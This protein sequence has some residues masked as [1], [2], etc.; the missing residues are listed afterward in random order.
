M[1]S[2]YCSQAPS[3][4][5][6]CSHRKRRSEE[7][8]GQNSLW[9]RGLDWLVKSPP[10][11]PPPRKA[12]SWSLWLRIVFRQAHWLPSA[13]SGGR[14]D[15]L[16]IVCMP[17]ANRTS[18]LEAVVA[19]HRRQTSVHTLAWPL[20]NPQSVTWIF[21]EAQRS[22]WGHSMCRSSMT[23]IL[24]PWR[25]PNLLPTNLLSVSPPLSRNIQPFSSSVWVSFHVA[26]SNSVSWRLSRDFGVEGPAQ[27][28]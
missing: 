11:S 7:V 6:T 23:R 27:L 1:P 25:I 2:C 17:N 9:T 4:K 19:P 22:S 21:H 8:R 16:Q 26:S 3:L 10:R 15:A 18:C 12:T 24:D 13:K 5:A 14:R 20:G 28:F